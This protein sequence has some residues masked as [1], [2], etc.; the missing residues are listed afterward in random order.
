M[1][2]RLPRVDITRW[3]YNIRTVNVVYE[4]RYKLEECFEVLEEKRTNRLTVNEA[5]G[6]RRALQDQ[7][8]MFWLTFFHRIL[9]HVDILYQELQS[10]NKES[11][12]WK[13]DIGILK[14]KCREGENK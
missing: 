5:S 14:M 10:R 7:N 12:M 8:F 11:V 9:P 4:N 1:Q 13:S 3:N 2:T 6:Q